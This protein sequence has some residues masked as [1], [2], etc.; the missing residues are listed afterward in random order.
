LRGVDRV[1]NTGILPSSDLGNGIRLIS[2]NYG[3]YKSSD[4]VIDVLALILLSQVTDIAVANMRLSTPLTLLTTNTAFAMAGHAPASPQMTLIYSMEAKLGNRFSLGS[5]PGGQERIVIPIVG[6][7]F[8][9]PRL[10]GKLF[11]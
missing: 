5:V 2:G 8:K 6:G 10:S 3:L 9:G 1:K 7:T 4:V 11:Q